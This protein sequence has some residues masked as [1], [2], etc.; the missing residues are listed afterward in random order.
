MN[1]QN[2]IAVLFSSDP[3]TDTDISGKSGE[4]TV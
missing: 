4:L 2:S 3:Q 1:M